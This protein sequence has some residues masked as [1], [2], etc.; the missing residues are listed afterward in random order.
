[1]AISGVPLST[2]TAV[3][4]QAGPATHGADLSDATGTRLY[5]I[6]YAQYGTAM[7]FTML[8]TPVS[9]TEPYLGLQTMVTGFFASAFAGGGPPVVAGF[10]TPSNAYT[11]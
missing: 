7:P 6:P 1:L 9:V 10:P 3:L 8:P 11:N 2:I 4:V 5:T